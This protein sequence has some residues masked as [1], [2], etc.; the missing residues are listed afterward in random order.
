MGRSTNRRVASRRKRLA[1]LAETCPRR[2]LEAWEQRLDSWISQF[3]DG[4]NRCHAKEICQMIFDDLNGL[5]SEAVKIASQPTIRK[6]AV[7]IPQTHIA[8]RQLYDI[9]N[10]YR[11]IEDQHRRGVRAPN[12]T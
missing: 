8:P 7:A 4:T 10:I 11:K 2:F 5:G 12:G 6:L 9:G 3:F 1:H